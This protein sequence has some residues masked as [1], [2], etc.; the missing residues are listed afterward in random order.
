MNNEE[1]LFIAL[2][3]GTPDRTPSISMSLD[4]NITNQALGHKPA[5]LLELLASDRG[6]RFVDKHASTINRFF[7]P[8][9]FAFYNQCAKANCEIG[10]DALWFGYWPM[11][12]RDH[13]QLEDVFGRLDDIVD[14]GF[15]NAY[16]MYRDGLLGSADE[17]RAWKRP[18]IARF[19]TT[20][21]RMYWLLK[22]IWG[23]RIAMVP[24]VGPGLWE[25]SWQPMG[26][27]RFVTLMRRDP[28]FVRE[29]VGYYTALCV[30]CVDAYCA[31]GARVLG[32]GEDLAYKSG[33]MISPEM[34]EKF[35]GDGYRQITSTAHRYG[36]KIAIHC[37][38]NTE[39][40]L[41]KFI[42]WGFDGAHALEPSAGNTIAAA[43]EKVGDRLCL[44]G[45]ID[46]T[47]TL[48]D[49][50]REEVEA[51]TLAA[52]RDAAGGG[53]ILSPAHTHPAMQ[54]RNL[55][56]MIEAARTAGAGKP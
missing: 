21:A 43:R 31:A 48:V 26:F 4:P 39:D 54:V 52:I 28:D 42:D 41:E 17:W 19:A 24:F 35:Y 20:A 25:N 27:T 16:F 40:L 51:E 2:S 37:C 10:F 49:A 6:S 53:F 45:N 14:D 36:A 23:N 34:L 3:G 38:G 47:H 5:K 7:G 15:G 1:R 44:I 13:S 18:T 46:I 22:A 12:F 30:A 56:W 50:T 33:S 11:G 32:F 29:A 8:A 55:K 9:E